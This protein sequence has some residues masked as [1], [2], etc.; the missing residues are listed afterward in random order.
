ME[1]WNFECLSIDGLQN[2]YILIKYCLL[3]D[4]STNIWQ[5][6]DEPWKHYTKLKEP[7]KK[8][9]LWIPFIWNIQKR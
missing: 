6:E 1:L 3:I 2:I 4:L 9:I 8:H 7:V 5:K